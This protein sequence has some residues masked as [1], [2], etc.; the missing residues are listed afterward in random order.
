MS[1]PVRAGS[2]KQSLRSSD[3]HFDTQWGVSHADM[4]F[5]RPRA[6]IAAIVA[7]GKGHASAPFELFS[8]TPFVSV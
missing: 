2:P 7:F 1:P 4:L 8:H 5:P 3:S 6:P